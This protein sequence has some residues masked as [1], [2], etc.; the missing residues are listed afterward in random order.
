MSIWCEIMTDRQN[1]WVELCVKEGLQTHTDCIFS[2]LCSN[3]LSRSVSLTDEH[4]SALKEISLKWFRITWAL[5]LWSQTAACTVLQ[6]YYIIYNDIIDHYVS[7]HSTLNQHWFINQ[8]MKGGCNSEIKE[9]QRT[10]QTQCQLVCWNSPTDLHVSIINSQT[11]CQ[12]YW[13]L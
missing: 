13:F 1:V 2:P 7:W 6:W 10:T 5:W 12:L 11:Q 4:A 3:L 9:R 8:M